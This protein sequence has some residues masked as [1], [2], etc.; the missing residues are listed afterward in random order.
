MTAATTD[1]ANV[2]ARVEPVIMGRDGSKRKRRPNVRISGLE[3][4]VLKK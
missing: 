2:G 4:R 3:R 1:E